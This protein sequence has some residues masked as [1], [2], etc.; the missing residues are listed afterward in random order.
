MK[1]IMENTFMLIRISSRA[2]P[3]KNNKTTE[4]HPLL[5]SWC[6]LQ[7]MIIKNFSWAIFKTKESFWLIHVAVM[8]LQ[9]Y[10]CYIFFT[11]RLVM[12]LH[13]EWVLART[14]TCSYSTISRSKQELDT[15]KMARNIF[16]YWCLWSIYSSCPFLKR[17]QIIVLLFLWLDRQFLRWYRTPCNIFKDDRFLKKKMITSKVLKISKSITFAPKLHLQ[18]STREIKSKTGAWFEPTT[19]R[20]LAYPSTNWAMQKV[21]K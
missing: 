15:D 3:S 18:N 16:I 20:L 9:F 11:R 14:F 2:A 5:I 19:H 7:L 6:T 12:L 13:F 8:F 17:N 21:N 4:N 10:F 1:L